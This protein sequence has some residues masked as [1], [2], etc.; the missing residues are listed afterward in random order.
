MQLL[1]PPLF[2]GQSLLL[3]SVAITLAM[4]MAMAM[5][6]AEELE[7]E[8]AVFDNSNLADVELVQEDSWY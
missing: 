2:R 8:H 6:K 5:A 3:I 4:A 7:F 1:L